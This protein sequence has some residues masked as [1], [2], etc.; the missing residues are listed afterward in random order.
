ML[1]PTIYI[2]SR[3]TRLLAPL[4]LPQLEVLPVLAGLLGPG[5]SRR[6]CCRFT[7]ALMERL[8]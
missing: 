5:N 3:L 4:V 1:R 2:P 7:T 8:N 6:P